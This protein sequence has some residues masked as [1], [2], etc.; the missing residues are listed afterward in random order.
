MLRKV[1]SLVGVPVPE[2]IP[3]LCGVSV[4]S[5]VSPRVDSSA[6]DDMPVLGDT[7][8]LNDVLLLSKV[9]LLVDASVPDEMNMKCKQTKWSIRPFFLINN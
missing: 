5:K 6:P 8:V 1:S 7:S 9:S 2:D 4:I 3:V